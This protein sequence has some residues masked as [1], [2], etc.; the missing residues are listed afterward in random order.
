MISKRKIKLNSF[1]KL[2][3]NNKKEKNNNT[4]LSHRFIHHQEVLLKNEHLKNFI[5]NN[6]TL[7]PKWKLQNFQDLSKA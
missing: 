3:E 1:K 7:I 5:K 6:K 4:L 2:R